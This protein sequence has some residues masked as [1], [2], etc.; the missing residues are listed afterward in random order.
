LTQVKIRKA[1]AVRLQKATMCG[2]YAVTELAAHADRQ[3]SAADIAEKYDISLNHLAKVLRALV[4]ARLVESVRGAGGG[5]RFAGNARRVT[6][7]DVIS[8]FEDIGAEAADPAPAQ[9][10]ARALHQVLREVDDFAVATLRATSL[11][12]L[13]RAIEKTRAAA[14]PQARTPTT[15]RA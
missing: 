13:V 5:Y 1:E 11:A 12:T 9:G 4:R 10:E 6:L 7:L 15:V 2:L 8:L 14:P 3:I